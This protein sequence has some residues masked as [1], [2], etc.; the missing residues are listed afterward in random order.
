[1]EN[2]HIFSEIHKHSFHLES[3]DSDRCN[4]PIQSNYM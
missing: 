4:D 1:M 2:S 3:R